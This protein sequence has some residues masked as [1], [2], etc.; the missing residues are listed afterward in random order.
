MH[1]CV[2]WPTVLINRGACWLLYRSAT[3]HHVTCIRV[4][5]VIML[6]HDNTLMASVIMCSMSTDEHSQHTFTSAITYR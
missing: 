5:H 3:D 2:M 6:V 1:Q 4:V